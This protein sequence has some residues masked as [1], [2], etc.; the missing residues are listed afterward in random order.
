MQEGDPR[1]VM[2]IFETDPGFGHERVTLV[3]HRETGLRAVIAIHDTTLGPAAGGCRMWPY[4][5]DRQA[6]ADA[7]RLSKA[8][9]WKN[10][11][12][13]MPLGGGKAVI[14]GNP[15]TEGSAELL[16]AFGA[17]VE[18]LGGAY[19]TAED[20]GVGLEAIRIVRQTCRYTFG[21]DR[22]PSPWTA[23]GTLMAI[24]A[25]VQHVFDD[26]SLDGRR[27]AVQGVGN[28]GG[29]LV[30]MLTERGAHCVVSDVNET[31]IAAMVDQYGVE[32]AGIDEIFDV[33]C[34]VFAPCALGGAVDDDTIGRLKAAIIAGS[35]NNQLADPHRHGELL[36]EAGIT[37]A[38][39]FVAN[40]GGMLAV[41]GEIHGVD[42]TDAELTEMVDAIRT[43]VNAILRRAAAADRPPAEI[44]TAMA[45]DKV[46][47]VR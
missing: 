5:N 10:A 30:G 6:L 33:P 43:R 38:P 47:A 3:Q 41:G 36:H 20:V 18:S 8:M 44:A 25:S 13:D 23:R 22:D 42:H 21:V 7:M 11:M 15:R 31:A 46:L 9:T 37:F 26:D 4:P 40:S 32:V 1:S 39:D 17:A 27:I 24:L 2:E 45:R 14:I 12:A 19:W 29:Q 35:A 34:D 16:H 28:V